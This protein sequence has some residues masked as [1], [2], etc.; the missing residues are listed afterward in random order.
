MYEFQVFYM[1]YIFASLEVG[2]WYSHVSGLGLRVSGL[3][4]RASALGTRYSTL[5]TWSLKTQNWYISMSVEFF[6]M[7]NIF[8]S[9][10]GTRYLVTQ[11]LKLVHFYKF[12][13]LYMIYIFASLEVGVWYSHVSGLGLR[14]SGLGSWHSVLGTWYLVTRDSKLVHFY[15]FQVFVHDIHFCEFRGWSLVL[16]GFGSQALGLG[17]QHSV[18]GT[19][20]LAL[21]TW[22]LVLG[23]SRLSWDSSLESRASGLDGRDSMFGT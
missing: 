8:A 4:S 15:E 23:H 3:G 16:P 20:H 17:S 10:L 22:H 1:I 9:A 19:Q 18:L 14:V 11:D 12:R 21:S 7:I 2:V 6:Y 5:G 13:V